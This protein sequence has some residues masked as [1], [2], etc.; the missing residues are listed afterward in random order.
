[1]DYFCIFLGVNKYVGLSH[2]TSSEYFFNEIKFLSGFSCELALVNMIKL[3]FLWSNL[4]LLG[5]L[6]YL[7][8]FLVN[9][10][11]YFFILRYECSREKNHLYSISWFSIFHIFIINQC[12]KSSESFIILEE[13]ISFINNKTF[14]S[15]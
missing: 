11:G 15:R 3:Q 8:L 14:Y 12:K 7:R 6:N 9:S 2:F 1:M 4:H 10:I 13:C 5:F